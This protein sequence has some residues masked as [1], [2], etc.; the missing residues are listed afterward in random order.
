MQIPDLLELITAHKELAYAAL[1]V[2]GV[3]AGKLGLYLGG[4][5]FRAF[6]SGVTWACTPRPPE[7]LD[8]AV[9]VLIEGIGKGVLVPDADAIA[10]N[11][12]TYVKDDTVHVV[13]GGLMKC[14]ACWGTAKDR[15]GEYSRAERKAIRA[16][17]AERFA[18]LK[19]EQRALVRLAAAT[20]EAV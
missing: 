2:A 8:E 4:K 5:A 11:P 1:G 15:S 17:Y 18:V 6:A 7:P 20:G 12:R 3:G 9:A 13:P 10:V 19:A 16:A 14:N